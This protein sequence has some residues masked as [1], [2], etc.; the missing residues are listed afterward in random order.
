M[1]FEISSLVR[2]V[3]P[4]L[5]RS[6]SYPKITLNVPIAQNQVKPLINIQLSDLVSSVKLQKFANEQLKPR[7]SAIKGV[8]NISVYGGSQ[9]EWVITYNAD[10]LT[11]LHLTEQNLRESIQ[12]YFEREPLGRVILATGQTLRVPLDN[13]LSNRNL[14]YWS[15]IQLVNRNGRIIY[16]TDV[17]TITRQDTPQDNLV[18]YERF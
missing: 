2:Q 14:N 17:V 9:Y 18:R 6:V 8:S 13:S 16:L 4:K 15:G 1:R 12:R 11:A 3:Y 5:L 10:A 7:L